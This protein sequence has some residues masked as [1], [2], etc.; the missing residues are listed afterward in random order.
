MAALIRQLQ[1]RSADAVFK[2]AL[3]RD[4]HAPVDTS[5]AVASNASL[6]GMQLPSS[7]HCGDCSSYMLPVLMRAAMG[8]KLSTT[9]RP[10]Q[11]PQ[12]GAFN[13]AVACVVST[14]LPVMKKFNIMQVHHAG[15][16]RVCRHELW[17]VSR[18]VNAGAVMLVVCV[19]AA[20]VGAGVGS[21][22]L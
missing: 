9:L 7:P 17:G 5:P 8:E 21:G 3:Q 12:Q 18:G 1:N 14:Y 22:K 4:A 13:R 19:V 16:C 20:N 10:Q 11:L 2:A 15:L 6:F